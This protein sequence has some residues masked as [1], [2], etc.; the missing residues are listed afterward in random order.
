MPLQNIIQVK[1]K[2]VKYFVNMNIGK[3]LDHK[4]IASNCV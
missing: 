4:T 3:P 2:Q 1:E